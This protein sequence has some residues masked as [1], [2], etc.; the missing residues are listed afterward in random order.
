MTEAVVQPATDGDSGPQD[1][2]AV[3]TVA[4][5]A[6]TL[7]AA[8][9]LKQWMFDPN[10]P[11]HP[12]RGKSSFAGP[13]DRN[14]NLKNKNPRK[15]LQ[16][17]K[18]FFGMNLGWTDDASPQTAVRVSR[19]FFTRPNNDESP[20]KYGDVFA[21]GYGIP[22]SY[23]HYSNQAVGI[24]LDWSTK[25]RFEW[26]IL[27]GPRG[28]QVRSG[29]H[30]ALYNRVAKEPMIHFPRKGFGGEIGWVSSTTILDKIEDA[31]LQF[32][33]DHWKEGLTYLI[34]L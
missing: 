25:P 2:A 1:R 11:P 22:P 16:W 19:W 23:V 3:S 30:V 4:V 26:E 7:K 9:H 14:T 20:I 18:Q 6:T 27:G 21:M 13:A 29:T 33:K 31:V 10:H 8:S 24:N 12:L 15:F 34:S 32:L 28:T 17:E 5:P